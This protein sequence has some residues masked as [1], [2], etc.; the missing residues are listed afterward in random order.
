MRSIRRVTFRVHELGDSKKLADVVVRI[1]NSFKASDLKDM[2]CARRQISRDVMLFRKEGSG[3]TL[4]RDEVDLST[5]LDLS[6][7]ESLMVVRD[8]GRMAV[9]T[10]DIQLLTT[11][12]WTFVAACGKGSFGSVSM[13]HNKEGKAFV[14][15]KI[16]EGETDQGITRHIYREATLL[17]QLSG[18]PHIVKLHSVLL[19]GENRDQCFFQFD[20][21]PKTLFDVIKGDARIDAGVVQDYARQL[22]RGL[23]SLHDCKIAHRDIKPQNLLVTSDNVLKVCDFG[24]AR[25]MAPLPKFYTTDVGTL[26]YRPPDLLLGAKTHSVSLD[27]WSAG[28]VVGEM[29][30]SK[31]LFP[32]DSTISMLKKIFGLTSLPNEHSWPGCTAFDGWERICRAIA[33]YQRD[34]MSILRWENLKDRRGDISNEALAVLQKLLTPAPGRRPTVRTALEQPWLKSSSEVW[35]IQLRL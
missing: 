28:C 14:V 10:N 15:K 32:G 6:D 29:W 5:L 11:A 18:H 1:R 24:L 20:L 30:L 16:L 17:R 8:K 7:K 26:W 13:V 2:I 31:A 21:V 12:G 35:D 19:L 25:C 34:N 23:E 27:I 3:Y 4:W 33:G 9:P 22:L